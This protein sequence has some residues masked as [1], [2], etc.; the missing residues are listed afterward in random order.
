M[1]NKP[2]NSRLEKTDS[3]Y[4]VRNVPLMQPIVDIIGWIFLILVILNFLSIILMPFLF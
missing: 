2:P 1:F 3:S 4:N